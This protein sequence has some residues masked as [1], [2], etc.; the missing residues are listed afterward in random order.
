MSRYFF[1]TT[2]KGVEPVLAAEL[3]AL[4]AGEVRSE[5]GG[6]AFTGD[7]AV[8]Y[9]ANLWLRTANRVLMPLREFECDS[10]Q[11]LYDGVRSIDWRKHLTTDMTFAIDANVRDSA[12]THSKYAALKAKDA[13]ADQLRAILG[14]RPNVDTKDPHLRINLHIARNRCAIGLD[15]SGESLHKRGYRVEPVTAPLKETLAAAIVLYAEWDGKSPFVD[16]MCGSGTIVIEAALKAA[17]IA[18]GLLRRRFG[19][20]RWKGFDRRVWKRLVD[21]AEKSRKTKIEAKIQG[22]DISRKAVE[23]A[24]KNATAASAG[25]FIAFSSKDF[26]EVR[27]PEGPG[28]VILNPP[29][30]E[31]LGQKKELEGVYKAI[32]DTFKQRFTGYTGY[33]FTGNLELAKQVGLR[34]S[35]RIIL[36]NGPIES[37]LLKYEL[38]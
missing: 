25:G 2:A 22:S 20:E 1:A 29:Y 26:A 34:A 38:Y 6:V 4:G 11:A 14:A 7:M 37:R 21:E 32:G 33:I 15:T 12:I 5:V 16:L 8:A 30:G 35:K 23:A 18:P 3:E 31:R 28:I 36:Y 17:N 27:P 9:K 13:I 24:K 19:F 10:D